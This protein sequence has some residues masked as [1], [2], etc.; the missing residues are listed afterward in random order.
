MILMHR[1]GLAKFATNHTHL[2]AVAIACLTNVA[3]DHPEVVASLMKQIEFA[4]TDIGDGDQLGENA[5]F[6]K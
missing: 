5:R 6:E 1:T 2:F 3:A 4:R